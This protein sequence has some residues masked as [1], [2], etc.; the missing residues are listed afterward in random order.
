MHLQKALCAAL[1]LPF[2][3]GA[4][5]PSRVTIALHPQYGSQESGAA[6]ITKRGANLVVDI[7][8]RRVPH[9]APMQL[10]HLHRGPCNRLILSKAIDLNP[11]IA[12][13]SH[14]ILRRVETERALASNGS[15]YVSV[16]KMLA[17]RSQHVACGG[18]VR[19]P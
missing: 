4:S 1:L 11:L 17:N 18:P 7:R 9:N 14:T 5:G 6:T 13:R 10:A 19:S 3:I 15:L 16:H 8:M 12:G 2:V